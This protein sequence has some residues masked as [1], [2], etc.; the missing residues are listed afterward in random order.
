MF[1]KPTNLDAE[2]HRD[3]RFSPNQPYDFARELVMI[4]VVAGE[5]TRV[6]REM[7]IVFPKG[8]GVPQALTGV[9]P[10]ENLHVKDSGHW[11]G[12]YIPAHIRRYPFVLAE[13]DVSDA[14]RAEKG[15]QFAVQFDA[16]ARHFE[17]PD[18]H[19]LLDA[20]GKPT[21]VLKKV[22]QILMG[23]QQD[24]ERT[25]ALVEQLD[26]AGLLVER[27]IQVNPAGNAANDS[28]DK[29]HALSGLRL[30]DEKALAKLDAD[31]LAKLRDSGALALAYAHLLSL[32]NLQDGLIAKAQ[33]GTGTEPPA[34]LD[35]LFGG[36]DDDFSF[37]FDS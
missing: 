23:L 2:Q 12:R 3:L 14:Q 22:Q 32:T 13:V 37:D 25:R 6:A 33:A 15:R 17:R 4:P 5:I 16:L 31:A 21:E 10:G 20:Q 1:L 7:P 34:N 36:S 28:E 18:G 27:N 11:L 35:E 8:E 29:S 9:N 26:Q 24:Q 30:V 19:A